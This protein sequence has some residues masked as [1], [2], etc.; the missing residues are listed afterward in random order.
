MRDNGCQVKGTRCAIWVWYD[1]LACWAASTY[2][3][4]F[5][6]VFHKR[7]DGAHIYKPL[8]T[9]LCIY[10]RD[11]GN[12]TRGNA[13]LSWTAAGKLDHSKI[14]FFEKNL[15]GRTSPRL[16]DSKYTKIM[17]FWPLVVE[18][19]HVE[20]WMR[21]IQFRDRGVTRAIFIENGNKYT[22]IN[23]INSSLPIIIRRKDNEAHT[24]CGVLHKT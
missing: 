3:N 18:I 5:S 11:I 15:L 20:G 21:K 12:I 10:Y 16:Y 9:V 7:F 24:I 23:D 13:P 6:T 8:A 14:D 19:S 1:Q 4:H 2:L 22:Y 17:S